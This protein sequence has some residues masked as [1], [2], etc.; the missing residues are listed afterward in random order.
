[1]S[2]CGIMSCP[3]LD[4]CCTGIELQSYE[5]QGVTDCVSCCDVK[6]A[7]DKRNNI[8]RS[9]NSYHLIPLFPL[10]ILLLL[11]WLYEWRLWE[12]WMLSRHHTHCCLTYLLVHAVPTSNS[13]PVFV[14][15]DCLVS[16]MKAASPHLFLLTSIYI[17]IIGRIASLVVVFAMALFS[18]MSRRCFSL[19][20]FFFI[21]APDFC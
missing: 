18:N 14:P 20:V 9:N 2:T 6:V 21:R 1:M 15:Q 4:V 19:F 7:Q 16:Q 11:L 12:L 13:F 8:T 10:A 5:E 3:L 17:F